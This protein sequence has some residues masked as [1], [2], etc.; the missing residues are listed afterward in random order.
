MEFLLLKEKVPEGRMRSR[1]EPVPIL[2][3]EAGREVH[4]HLEQTYLPQAV[5]EIL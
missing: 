2:Y 1:R 3:R 4:N 5:A